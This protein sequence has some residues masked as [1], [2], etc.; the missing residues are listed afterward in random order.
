[1]Q[2][3]EGCNPGRRARVTLTVSHSDTAEALSSGDVPVLASPR[4]V[5]L[6]EQASVLAIS[7]CL[8]E[9]QTSVGAWAELDHLTPTAVGGTV[10]AEST[11]LGVHG[12]RLEFTVIVRQDG[13]EIAR[14]RHRRV[15]VNRDRFLVSHDSA[16]GPVS[17]SA[18]EGS[19][20]G[21]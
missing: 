7:E 18:P 21:S 16:A 4:V 2:D 15:L 19:E 12:R 14:M 1:M 11:L 8:P 6:A 3:V 13:E 5:A 17:S 10:E 20:P 9:G